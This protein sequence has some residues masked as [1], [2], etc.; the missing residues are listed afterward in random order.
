MVRQDGSLLSAGGDTEQMEIREVRLVLGR[1]TGQVS[2]TKVYTGRATRNGLI[3]TLS[4]RIIR[5]SPEGNRPP[6]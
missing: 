2:N 1:V 6:L 5:R 3:T 4:M